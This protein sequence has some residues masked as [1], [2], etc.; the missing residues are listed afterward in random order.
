MLIWSRHN[1][2]G[3]AVAQSPHNNPP[4]PRLS[5]L[6][7][8]PAPRSPGLPARPRRAPLR[9]QYHSAPQGGSGR[10]GGAA[11]EGRPG[12]GSPALPPAR[13]RGPRRRALMKSR[14]RRGR[15][16][17]SPPRGRSGA[18]AEAPAGP[19]DSLPSR[20]G[21]NA[22][23]VRGEARRD[24]RRPGPAGGPPLP[25]GVAGPGGPADGPALSSPCGGL[26]A[27]CQGP[28][29][30]GGRVSRASPP[31][32]RAWSRAAFGFPGASGRGVDS[33]G[34]AAVFV[35]ESLSGDPIPWKRPVV[36]S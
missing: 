19:P 7:P 13:S 34:T 27:G 15:R 10:R 3:P 33:A 30:D 21:R 2:P 4:R 17:G 31:C 12:R 29:A 14:A 20:G 28:S 23:A 35:S 5:P 25:E 26:A 9:R 6:L 24:P 22:A 1:R 36:P 11:G 32:G 18:R 16:A 8:P